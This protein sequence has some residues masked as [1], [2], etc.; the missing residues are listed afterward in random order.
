METTG[1][2][3]QL[4]MTFFTLNQ[5]VLLLQTYSY[6]ILFPV[7]V[8]EGPIITILAGFFSAHGALIWYLALATVVVGDLVGDA[9]YYLCGRWGR[10]TFLARW[11]KHIGIE[12]AEIAKIE[13]HFIKHPGKTLLTAKWTHVAGLPVLVTA[14]ISKMRFGLFM[15]YSLIGTVVKS[16]ILFVV[17]YYAGEAYKRLNNYFD[18]MGYVSTLIIIAIVVHIVY[19]AQKKRSLKKLL[20]NDA[21]L[22]KNDDEQNIT[23]N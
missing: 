9:I 13:E 23:V 6:G 20:A 19:R 21:V 14:G 4:S 8:I 17:G 3:V 11:G 12:E 15:A 18:L 10:N 2:H 16:G 1:H 7:A 5:V 22:N